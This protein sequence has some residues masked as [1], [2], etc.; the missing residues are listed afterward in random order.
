MQAENIVEV[1]A[2]LLPTIAG[3]E[4]AERQAL[5]RFV[6]EVRLALASVPANNSGMP[7]QQLPIELSS[8]SL[9]AYN[10]GIS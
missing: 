6:R 5:E 4:R 2:K 3:V 7:A 9:Q 8:L 10:W 1:M